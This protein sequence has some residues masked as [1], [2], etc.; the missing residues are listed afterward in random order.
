MTVFGSSSSGNCYSLTDNKGRTLILDAGVN[1]KAVFKKILPDTIEAVLVTHEHGDHAK[2]ISV[3]KDYFVTVEMPTDMGGTMVADN[4]VRE[5]G[6]FKIL[7]FTLKHDVP[8]LGYLINHPELNGEPILYAT[9][10]NGIPYSFKKL[11]LAMIEA[12]YDA[13]ILKDNMLKGTIEKSR[14]KRVLQSHQSIVQAI[15]FVEDRVRSVKHILLVHLSQDNAN[16]EDFKKR[17]EAAT[18]VL[19]DI[20]VAGLS[21]NINS[22]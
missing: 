12:D 3:F 13:I 11:S 1:P 18:G 8:C 21:I 20:A 4:K 17:M 14:V 22:F 10:T 19:T 7:A 2:Y 15:D 5:F 6:E 16:R 9:D